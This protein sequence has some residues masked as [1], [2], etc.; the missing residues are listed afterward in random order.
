MPLKPGLI[1]V[2]PVH[3]EAAPVAVHD[4]DP[5]LAVYS[6]GLGSP[7][8]LLRRKVPDETTH[9]EHIRIGPE[10]VLSHP[11]EPGVSGEGSDVSAL[12]GQHLYPF[13][14]LVGHVYITVLVDGYTRRAVELAQT[15]SRGPE[16]R[17]EPAI[18]S[19][20]LYPVVAPV[21]HVNVAVA[22]NGQAP[23]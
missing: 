19:E 12:G 6:N 8:A 14:E 13:V 4:E 1:V 9:P 23:G 2:L 5:S 20:F 10:L 3:L 7:E 21:R 16:L 17:Q 15:T 22:V 11:R 18:W